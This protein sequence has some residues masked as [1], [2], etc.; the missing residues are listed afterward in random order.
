MTANQRREAFAS[1]VTPS[2]AGL[3]GVSIDEGTVSVKIPSSSVDVS[4]L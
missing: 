1:A 2:V 4:R 3:Q